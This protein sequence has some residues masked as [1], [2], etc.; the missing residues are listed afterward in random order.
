[1]SQVGTKLELSL[2]S[3]MCKPKTKLPTGLV[4]SANSFCSARDLNFLKSFKINCFF[5]I[6]TTVNQWN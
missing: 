3:Y 4:I 6:R 2:T 5:H 1:M